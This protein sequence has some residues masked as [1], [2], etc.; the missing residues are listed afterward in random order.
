VCDVCSLN[1]NEWPAGP[2]DQRFARFVMVTMGAP[3]SEYE[4]LKRAAID[5]VQKGFAVLPLPGIR[6]GRRG[7]GPCVCELADPNCPGPSTRCQFFGM[8]QATRNVEHI[9]RWWGQHPRSRVGLALGRASGLAA[10]IVQGR[11]GLKSLEELEV[12]HVKLPRTPTICS[13][14]GE[15]VHLFAV[16]F[17]SV[18]IGRQHIAPGLSVAGEG[19]IILVPPSSQ[20]E[21]EVIEELDWDPGAT[22][23]QTS[24]ARMPPWILAGRELVSAAPIRP[25]A[26]DAPVPA[27]RTDNPGAL[28]FRTGFELAADTTTVWINKPWVAVKAITL[29]HGTGKGSG[30]TTLALHLVRSVLERSDFLL[31]PSIQGP[32]VLLTSES[33]A[34]L[35]RAFDS[36]GFS[37]LFLNHL[38]V[39]H[40]QDAVNTSWPDVMDGTIAHCRSVD[41]RLVV[42]DRLNVF[43]CREQNEGVPIVDAESVMH[44]LIRATHE[45]IGVFAVWDFD[46]TP[47]Q[48][49]RMP[50]TPLD[51]FVDIKLHLEV[52]GDSSRERIIL[53]KS[54]FDENPRSSLIQLREGGFEYMFDQPGLF[55][56]PRGTALGKPGADLDQPGS[57]PHD[58]GGSSSQMPLFPDQGSG[59]SS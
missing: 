4:Q 8:D 29:L 17:S 34:S 18:P 59:K 21:G 37:H 51:A 42:I 35:G 38:H 15:F 57:D 22:L 11:D 30:R 9:E 45:G 12:I 33:P 53:S 58:P 43:A 24:I 54:R 28:R 10:L 7:L 41:A 27:P 13:A 31:E 36:R 25:V 1:S 6:R 32:V 5:L 49:P 14:G 52:V 48:E 55:Q 23:N 16:D 56:K 19:E 40:Y 47:D 50:L 20:I 3:L 39:L 46:R 44:P 26:T 2:I